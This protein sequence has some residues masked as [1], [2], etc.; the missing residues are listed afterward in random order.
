M[1][2]PTVGHWAAGGEGKPRLAEERPRVSF[3]AIPLSL[4][5]D[6]C[7]GVRAKD[8]AVLAVRQPAGPVSVTN[9]STALPPTTAVMGLMDQLR[10]LDAYPKTLDD[11][12]VRTFSGAA[13]S[14]CA[15]ILMVVR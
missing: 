15:G 2:W 13:V 4:I 11:F 3:R 14:I 12:R 6:T 1:A 5:A 8:R 7:S 10:S 9:R